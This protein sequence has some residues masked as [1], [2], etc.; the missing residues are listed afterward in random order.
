MLRTQ[1]DGNLILASCRRPKKTAGTKRFRMRTSQ[2]DAMFYAVATTDAGLARRLHLQLAA[3]ASNCDDSSRSDWLD[4]LEA[5]LAGTADRLD[6]QAVH[7]PGRA[8]SDSRQFEVLAANQP[9]R[10]SATAFPG[11]KEQ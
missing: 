11:G 1:A 7:L 5:T 6:W 8:G 4:Q 9:S 10:R 2:T 3:G